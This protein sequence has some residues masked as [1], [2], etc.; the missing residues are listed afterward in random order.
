MYQRYTIFATIAD[1][2]KRNQTIITDQYLLFDNDIILSQ[3]TSLMCFQKSSSSIEFKLTNENL[4]IDMTIIDEE[5]KDFPINFTCSPSV[6]IGRL[7]EI[8]CQLFNVNNKYYSFI[9][10]D[11]TEADD[12]LSINELYNSTVGIYFK[13]VSKADAKCSIIYKEKE[14]RILANNSTII[15]EIFEQAIEKFFIPKQR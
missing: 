7:F 15:Q 12:D 8:A 5:Q 1:V 13:L 4:K 3:T 10:S 9:C 2:Y 14:I 6:K 11:D